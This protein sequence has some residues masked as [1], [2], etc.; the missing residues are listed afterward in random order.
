[1]MLFNDQQKEG[2]WLTQKQE[3]AERLEHQ[4][5][6]FNLVFDGKLIF[7]PLRNFRNVLDL[8]YGAASWAVEVAEN[9]PDCEVRSAS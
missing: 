8:G 4:N 3:E 1:M 6:V 5:R 9:Y 2:R 7:P